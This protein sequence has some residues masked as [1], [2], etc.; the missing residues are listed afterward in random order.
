MDLL[1]PTRRS[2]LVRTVAAS[3]ILLPACSSQTDDLRASDA[4]ASSYPTVDALRAFATDLQRRT[5]GRLNVSIYPNG[6]LGSENDTLELAQFGGIDF[7][8]INISPL[9]VVARETLVPSLPFLFRST[10]HMRA[11]MDGPPGRRILDAL[12]PHNLIGLCFYDS[13]ARSFYTSKRL[14]HQ[15]SDLR[16]LKI[17]VQ[18]SDLLVATIKALG[19]D[20]TPMAYSEV[21][22]G[23]MQE[24]STAQKTTGRHMKALATSRSRLTTA[25]RDMSWLLKSSQCLAG[26]GCGCRRP[27]RSTFVKQRRLR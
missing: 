23:L 2:L 13:G 14:I 8:R 10:A 4:Q 6:Q 24:S 7:I 15:P 11:A 19:G 3:G 9:N 16:G 26:A 20:A 22:Q 25:R 27:T 21:Y 18:S 12:E 17:R 5:S 1:A